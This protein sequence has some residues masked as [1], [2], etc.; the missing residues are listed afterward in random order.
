VK[1]SR[2]QKD[3]AFV[4]EEDWT[5]EKAV[6]HVPL[7]HKLSK[8]KAFAKP[9]RKGVTVK[10]K[11]IEALIEKWDPFELSPHLSSFATTGTTRL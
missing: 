2:P 4:L 9:S 10:Y 6:R 11:D 5:P 3:Q 1:Q 8:V 7:K